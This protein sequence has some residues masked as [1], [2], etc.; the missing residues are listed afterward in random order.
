MTTPRE[1][2]LEAALREL[3]RISKDEREEF[4]VTCKCVYCV[5]EKLI[6]SSPAQEAPAQDFEA[7]LMDKHAA[8]YTGLDDEMGDNCSEWIADLD[9]NDL[10]KY[11]NEW[12]ALKTEGLS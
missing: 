11:A 9:V 7:F 12:A 8:Q 4:S 3:L 10:I 6:A 5:A 1:A 2:Q